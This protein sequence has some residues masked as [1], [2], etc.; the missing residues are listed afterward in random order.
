MLF[1]E[2]TQNSL[3]FFLCRWAIWPGLQGLPIHRLSDVFERFYPT[4]LSHFPARSGLHVRK[5]QSFWAIRDRVRPGCIGLTFRFPADVWQK[6]AV[7]CAIVPVFEYPPSARP[8]SGL[9]ASCSRCTY[10]PGIL[11]KAKRPGQIL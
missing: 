7:A 3:I 11:Q 5:S 1:C 9:A 4:G 8:V 6:S 10:R 2:K